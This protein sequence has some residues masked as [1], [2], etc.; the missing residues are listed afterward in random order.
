MAEELVIVVEGGMVTSVYSKGCDPVVEV[1][2]LDVQDEDEYNEA[3]NRL[4]EIEE[5]PT[6]KSVW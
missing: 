2:D 1:I 3:E 6:F 4:S 5:D